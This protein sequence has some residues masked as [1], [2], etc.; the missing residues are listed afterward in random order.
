MYV[1]PNLGRLFVVDRR[2][3]H[4]PF[5]VDTLQFIFDYSR[6][7]SQSQSQKRNNLSLP[8]LMFR[9][10]ANDTHH[11]LAVNDLAFVTHFLYRSTNFHF[12]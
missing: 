4:V 6:P 3:L 11:T 10:D 2:Q 5:L 9:I 12:N 7:D 1:S 8:L